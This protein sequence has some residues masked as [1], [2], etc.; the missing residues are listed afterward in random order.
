M[1]PR[2]FE[3]MQLEP[4]IWV[5]ADLEA[6][7]DNILEDYPAREGLKELFVAPIGNL[8]ERLGGEKVEAMCRMLELGQWRELVR[9]LM[10]NYYDPLYRHTLP[11]SRVEVCLDAQGAQQGLKEA[12]DEVL[13]GDD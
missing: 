12:I 11:Q 9:E 3:A 1:P 10:V 6:R 7:V 8:R 4:S 13:A 2:F 5:E